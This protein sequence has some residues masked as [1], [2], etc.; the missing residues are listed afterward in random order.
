MVRG[1]EQW[2]QW[3]VW[4]QSRAVSGVSTERVSGSLQWGQCRGSVGSVQCNSAGEVSGVSAVVVSAGGSVVVSAGGSVGH[5]T[6]IGGSE[7]WG[8]VQG[9]GGSVQGG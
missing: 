9:V 5:H 2:G 3:A 7:Q 4:C 6:G 8:V 1:G